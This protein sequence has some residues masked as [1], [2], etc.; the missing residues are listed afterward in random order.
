M[1][2]KRVIESNRYKRINYVKSKMEMKNTSILL[3]T[4]LPVYNLYNNSV[5]IYFFIFLINNFN[6]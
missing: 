3:N 5:N 4:I 1:Y 6:K 2:V